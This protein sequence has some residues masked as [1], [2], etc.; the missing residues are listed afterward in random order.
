MTAQNPSSTLMYSEAQES[1]AVLTR[2]FVRNH[3]TMQRLATELRKLKPRAVITCARG[4]SDHAATFAKYLI[5]TRAGTLTSSAAPSISS[6]YF[7]RQ[8]LNGCL[9]LTISQSGKSPDLLATAHAAKEAGAVLVALVNAEDSP[10]AQMADFCLPLCAGPERSVA[11]TKSFIA[12]LAALVH[13]VAA[14][15][16]D[17]ELLSALADAPV[18]LERSWELDWS[19]AA[20][21]LRDAEHLFVMAR[22]IGLG[23]ALEA[24]LKCKETS[25]LHAEGFS[26]AEVQHGPQALLGADFPAMM[27]AQND[28]TRDGLCNV[29]RDL[30]DRGVPVWLAGAAVPGTYTLPTM[31]CHPVIEP[32]LMIQSFYK[33]VNSLAVS[34]GLN[35]DQPAH[36]RKVTET[37]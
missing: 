31:T 10:L 37:V 19:E 28:E 35:P 32:L 33:M 24:A 18:L 6:V 16:E 4:S 26:S 34:R 5:E 12:S 7:A 29:A 8:N 11:A 1:A 2:Q 27:L 9:F 22:G 17:A 30:A 13:L 14:W 23:I 36:L 25:G 15:T 21:Q 20:K 3:G